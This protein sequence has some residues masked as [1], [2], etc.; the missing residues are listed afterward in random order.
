[1]REGCYARVMAPR[2]RHA[3]RHRA[4]LRDAG[5]SLALNGSAHNWGMAGLTV[6]FVSAP[7]LLNFL[8]IMSNYT[9]VVSVVAAGITAGLFLAHL[10]DVLRH[11][12]SGDDELPDYDQFHDWQSSVAEPVL[13]ILWTI[14]VLIAPWIAW[15][16]AAPHAGL[17]PSSEAALAWGL[18]VVGFGLVPIGLVATAWGGVGMVFRVDLLARAVIRTP[19]A[20]ALLLVAL[21]MV[22]GLTAAVLLARA[23]EELL[24]G[25]LMD[26]VAG[27]S[28]Y[29]RY[30]TEWRVFKVPVLLEAV[31]VYALLQLARLMGLYQRHFGERLPWAL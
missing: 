27:G 7:Y 18:G 2:R 24:P 31:V 10:Q 12:A 25:F 16:L 11:T 22:I 9:L 26:W 21:A 28:P 4:F 29:R 17:H 6:A 13:T 8:P 23:P 20:Y 5:A 30:I 3:R 15:R 1:V 19:A 14:G